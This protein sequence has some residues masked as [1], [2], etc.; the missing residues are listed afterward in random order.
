MIAKNLETSRQISTT[1]VDPSHYY[2]QQ[3]IEQE[4]CLDAEESLDVLDYL[5]D[6]EHEFVPL[7][8]QATC[9]LKGSEWHKLLRRIYEAPE[10]LNVEVVR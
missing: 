10:N 7:I 5:C 8:L 9:V 1:G 3:Q 2:T 6:R 4:W